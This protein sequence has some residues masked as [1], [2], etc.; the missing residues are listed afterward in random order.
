MAAAP[1]SKNAGVSKTVLF[2]AMLFSLCVGFY[3][4]SFLTALHSSPKADGH[5]ADQIPAELTA[6][7]RRLEGLSRKEPGNADVWI[8]LG[9]LYYD[10]HQHE[11]AINAYE[12]ALRLSPGVPD[13]LVDLG[14]MYRAVRQPLKAVE[15]FDKALAVNGAHQ[16]ALRNKGAV[17]H[18]DLGKTQEAKEAWRALL[19]IN[20]NAALGDGTKLSVLLQSL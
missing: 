2:L 12:T 1:S 15:C 9:N 14:V 13:V 19:R 5:A 6:E 7:L 3:A 11:E 17:L 4:G 10:L 20:P 16:F 8:N 18:Y